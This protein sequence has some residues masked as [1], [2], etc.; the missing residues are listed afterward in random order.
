MTTRMLLIQV[1][2]LGLRLFVLDEGLLFLRFLL[3]STGWARALVHT[4]L[5]GVNL[6]GQL[7]EFAQAV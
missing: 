6:R 5:L 1:D 7:I 4:H 3:L 2:N